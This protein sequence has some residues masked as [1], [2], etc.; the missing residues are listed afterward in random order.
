MSLDGL[1]SSTEQYDELK[2]SSRR[3]KVQPSPKMEFFRKNTLTEACGKC[4]ICQEAI[5]TAPAETTCCNKW[6]CVSCLE[7]LYEEDPCPCCRAEDVEWT[8]VKLMD[9]LLDEEEVFCSLCS[10]R[11]TT[12]ISMTRHDYKCDHI[13]KEFWLCED[14]CPLLIRPCIHEDCTF[15]GKLEN[16]KK[17]LA[18]DCEKGYRKLDEEAIRA[19]GGKKG[20]KK[21]Q[22]MIEDLLKKFPPMSPE[23]LRRTLADKKL[24]LTARWAIALAGSEED[25]I[26]LMVERDLVSPRS[27]CAKSVTHI[28]EYLFKGIKNT[29]VDKSKLTGEPTR[30][31][32]GPGD[33]M[34]ELLQAYWAT[35]SHRVVDR[36]NLED[37][38]DRDL[39]EHCKVQPARDDGMALWSAA[40]E[41]PTAA[42]PTPM[43]AR[44]RSPRR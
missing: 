8:T 30:G 21:S 25:E 9:K 23:D 32:L 6:A 26:D 29:V 5:A 20:L 34:Y 44:E 18:H 41:A 28:T 16:L 2:S 15:H 10:T 3:D 38:K 35:L 37:W 22:Q 14:P 40:F 42:V 24:N 1:L 36:W 11:S 13:H 39:P 17:H 12:T 4:F 19:C 43:S 27:G 33:S 7:E 31:T